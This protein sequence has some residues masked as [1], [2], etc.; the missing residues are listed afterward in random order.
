M[1][2]FNMNACLQSVGVSENI[3]ALFKN[4]LPTNESGLAS[5]Q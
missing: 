3:F 4:R 2:V 5:K 1:A